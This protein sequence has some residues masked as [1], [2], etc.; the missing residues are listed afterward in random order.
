MNHN[1]NQ[2]R[3]GSI[4]GRHKFVWLLLLPVV[5]FL[6]VAVCWGIPEWNAARAN[7]AQFEQWAAM[8]IPYDNVS[9]QKAYNERTHPEGTA[10]WIQS[11]HLINWGNQVEAFKQLPYL[12]GEGEE[13]AVLIPGGSPIDWPKEPLVASYLKEMKPVIDLIEQASSHPTPVR[14]PIKFQGI[15]TLLPHVQN[16][17]SIQRLLSLDCDYAYFSKDNGRA[18]RDLSLMEATVDAY[19]TREC[20]VS[21]LVNV[22]LRGMRM[23]ALRRTLTN[24]QW[25]ASELE[26]LRDSL[27]SKEDISAKWQDIMV[28]ERAFGLSAVGEPLW[29]LAGLTGQQGPTRF[30]LFTGPSE[31]KTLMDAYQRIIEI[32]IGSDISSWR[33][34]AATLKGW[35]NTLPSNSL[36]GMLVPATTGVLEAEIRSEEVRRWTLTA[37]AIQQF[38]QKTE[39]WP[40]DLVELESVGLSYQDYSDTEKSVFGYEIEGDKAFLWKRRPQS[41]EGV[42]KTRPLP[43]ENKDLSDVVLELN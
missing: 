9:L 43:E 16:A 13:P 19:D 15:R 31:V 29:K 39:Q 30:K 18:L 10:D 33:K 34:R 7:R 37:V 23:R 41:E 2:P 4:L 22:A 1:S 12:G 32:P 5:V 40:K 3:P 17:R 36:A 8:E 24:C 6:A 28:N 21:E 42:S 14:F 20:L 35:V 11:T 26:I 38:K 27:A 25:S